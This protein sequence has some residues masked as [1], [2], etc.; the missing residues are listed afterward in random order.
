MDYPKSDANAR[1]HNDKFTDGDPVNAVPASR[2]SAVYQNAVYDELI[3]IIT[4]A[5]LDPEETDLGQVAEAIGKMIS[6]NTVSVDAAT[7]LKAGITKLSNSIVSGDE[8]VAATSKAVNDV[9]KLVKASRFPICG[10][11]FTAGP[12]VSIH[13]SFGISSVVRI[14]VGRYRVYFNFPMASL[15]YGS[16]TS[17]GNLNNLMN[18]TE[19][20]PTSVDYLD[21][22]VAEDNGVGTNQVCLYTVLIYGDL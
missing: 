11:V 14:S 22:S 6:D 2:D 8:T 13:S 5:G 20:S 21:V 10:A 12:T 9:Y 19:A 4:A 17:G 7:L 3:N 1:L 18:P 15:N 16:L